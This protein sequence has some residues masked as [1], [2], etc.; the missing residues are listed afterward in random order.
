MFS[1][2]TLL[3]ATALLCFYFSNLQANPRAGEKKKGKKKKRERE[4]SELPHKYHGILQHRQ[5]LHLSVKKVT[6]ER[7]TEHRFSSYFHFPE[8]AEGQ[9]KHPGQPQEDK[10]LGKEN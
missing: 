10:R 1:C 6:G 4:F 8:F 9:E 5:L 2:C 7:L 3:K